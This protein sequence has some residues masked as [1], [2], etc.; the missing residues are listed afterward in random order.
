MGYEFGRWTG[1]RLSEHLE[2]ETG[3]KLSKSQISRIL[4]REKYVYIWGKYSLEDKQDKKK[5]HR[6][7]R[8]LLGVK[9]EQE[10]E[11]FK[12][13]L[14]EYLNLAKEKP[15]S[16]QVWFWD[17][18]GFSL[19]V[20]RRRCWTKKGKRKK[21]KGQRRRGRVNIMGGLRYSD[22]KRICFVIKKG[23]SETFYEQLKQLNN[24][25]RQEWSSQGNNPQDF[26]EKGP[27]I[28]II[29]DNASFHKKQE[30]ID[31]IESELP[32]IR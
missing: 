8:G 26:R 30:I 7:R 10:R 15:E 17:E 32:N 24:Q 19:R 23:N 18:C 12:E 29:L 13:K 6:L 4:S 5:A 16:I 28:V 1:K 3:I 20:I 21:V 31:K 25:V 22:K 9:T 2:K 11:V 14:S 27:K